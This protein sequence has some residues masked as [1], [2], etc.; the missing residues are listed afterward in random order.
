MPSLQEGLGLSIMEA[1]ASGV[2]VVASQVGGITTL[3]RN[4]ETG[5]LV[6]P[7]DS[8]ALAQA[9]IGLLEDREKA[10]DVSFKAR[11][12]IDKHFSQEGMVLKTEQVYRVCL[13]AKK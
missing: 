9:I 4:N 1:M 13:D 6:A 7:K 12:F 5:L 11:A 10:N 2:P 3:I 8:G